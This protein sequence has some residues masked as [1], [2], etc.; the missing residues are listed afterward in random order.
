MYELTAC[1][2]LADCRLTVSVE[3]LDDV[4]EGLARL[5]VQVADGDTGGEDSIIL[6]RWESL[7]SECSALGKSSE[8]RTG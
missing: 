8:S 4:R 7:V 2:I 1:P 6:V 3:V 5:L